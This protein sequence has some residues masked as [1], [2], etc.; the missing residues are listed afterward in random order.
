MENWRKIV[1]DIPK[2]DSSYL[3][4]A[5]YLHIEKFKCGTPTRESESS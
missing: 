5:T 4:P 1:H 2:Y 3:A